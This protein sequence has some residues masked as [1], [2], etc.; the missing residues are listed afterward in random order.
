VPTP[1]R[2]KYAA[3]VGSTPSG[4]LAAKVNG[5]IPAAASTSAPRRMVIRACSC[6]FDFTR[7]PSAVVKAFRRLPAGRG[8]REC[9]ADAGAA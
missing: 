8:R 1:A 6:G 9:D 3:V 5:L 2:T 4:T 7:G